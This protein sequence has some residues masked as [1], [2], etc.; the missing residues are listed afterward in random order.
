MIDEYLEGLNEGKKWDAVKNVW[1]DHKGKILVGA[2]LLGSVKA[3]TGLRDVAKK[4]VKDLK[5]KN[6]ERNDKFQV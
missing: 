6:D 2:T 4:R 5:S 1:R 3:V